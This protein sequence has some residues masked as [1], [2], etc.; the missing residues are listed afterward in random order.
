V[1]YESA[2][3][4]LESAITEKVSRRQPHRLERM[5]V[6]LREL[7]EP[8]DTYPTVH[9]GGTSGK[10]STSTMI[11]AALSAAGKRTGLHSKPH[12][13]SVTERARI[14]GVPIPQ[15]AFGEL[16]SEIM[17]AI[18]RTALEHGRPSYYET[19]LA[20]A[21]AYFAQ[22]RVDVAVIEVG[23]G[24]LLDGTNVL[25]PKVSV[26]TNVGLDHTDVLGETLEEIAADKAG[27]AKPGVPLVTGTQDRAAREVIEKHCEEIGTPFLYVAQHARIAA[28]GD[29]RYGQAFTVE[30]NADTDARRSY[31]LVLPILGRFQ[32]RNAAAAI[33]ALEQLDDDLR[34]SVA[35][36]ERG[37]EKV[38]IPGRMEYFAGHPGVLF[39][40][41]HNPDKA[42]NLADAL[43]ET[44]G[45]RR[46]TFVV[47]IAQSKDAPGILAPLLG[48]NAS[49][50]FTSFD[51]PGR[52]AARPQRLAIIAN[53]GGASARTIEIPSEALAVARRSADASGI[54]VVTGSTFLVAHLRDW[55]LTHVV[56]RAAR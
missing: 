54:I 21:F 43:V 12:L 16:L 45:N 3:A 33:V 30:T 11:A 50:V 35:E 38:V 13:Q 52:S 15:D 6:L 20:L 25:S 27:I 7:G 28:Q 37:L 49:F 55:W 47:G 8:Q 36:V 46:F 41:A 51:T 26:I 44:F 17:P 48:L 24:G 9:V 22:E 10:G 32:Q 40:I 39:D 56:E 4:Y 2:V 53:V 42:R 14:D 18:E 34:P 31:N 1:T 5:R 19:L 29:E 23:L